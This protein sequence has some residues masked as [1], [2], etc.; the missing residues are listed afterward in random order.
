MYDA[1]IAIPY[2]IT[3]FMQL[4]NL[5][6]Q[7]LPDHLPQTGQNGRIIGTDPGQWFPC[8]SQLTSYVEPLLT[9]IKYILKYLNQ[10]WFRQEI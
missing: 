5:L 3:R 10:I 9:S 1:A 7:P 6:L 4:P 8:Q 2:C